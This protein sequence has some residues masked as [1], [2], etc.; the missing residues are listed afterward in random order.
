MANTLL[1]YGG[2]EGYVNPRQD[3]PDDEYGIMEALMSGGR[4]GSSRAR[5]EGQ[6]MIRKR[7]MLRRLAAKG[8]GVPWRA[9]LF[10]NRAVMVEAVTQYNANRRRA[11]DELEVG[12]V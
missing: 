5:Y 2:H 10:A 11:R 9:L 12:V 8:K 3:D 4:R 6:V 1:T 7:E